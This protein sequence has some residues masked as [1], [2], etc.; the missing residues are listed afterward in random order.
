M[1]KELVLEDRLVVLRAVESIID[2][3]LELI[4]LK[5]IVDMTGISRYQ[6]IICGPTRTG[7]YETSV[8]IAPRQGALFNKTVE[9]AKALLESKDK[10]KLRTIGW[11]LRD[12]PE[13]REFKELFPQIRIKSDFGNEVELPKPPI[14]PIRKLEE[15]ED[16]YAGWEL[17][18]R[19]N[20]YHVNHKRSCKFV[21]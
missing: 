12:L 13:F 5:E 2:K 16:P 6:F 10:N 17:T 15:E 3:K 19:D 9:E 21:K 18:L 20:R 11:I 8:L 14:I 7:G 1:K 4:S